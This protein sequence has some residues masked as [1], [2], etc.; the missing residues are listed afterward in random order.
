MASGVSIGALLAAEMAGPT[1][2][3]LSGSAAVIGAALIAIPA[4]G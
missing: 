1:A 2:A 4:T 3:G